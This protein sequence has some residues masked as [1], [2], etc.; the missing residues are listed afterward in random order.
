VDPWLSPPD[1]MWQAEHFMVEPERGLTW[2]RD[3]DFEIEGYT[4]PHLFVY[5]DGRFGM[6][7]GEMHGE[8]FEARSVLTSDDGL[9]W[10]EGAPLF[11][12]DDFPIECGERL[13][14]ATVWI[15]TED[16]YLFILEGYDES[17]SEED[18]PVS[19]FC[20][21][22][23]PDGN[24]FEHQ[25]SYFYE[26]GY[27]G[28]VF[29]VPSAI[30]RSDGDALLFYM[31]HL[32]GE[33]EG[34]HVLEADAD[35]LATQ[36]L[37]DGSIMDEHHVDPDPVYL[38]DGGLRLYHT[39]FW[40]LEQGGMWESRGLAYVPLDEDLLPT[41]EATVLVESD[42]DAGE[43]IFDPSMVRLH[44][45]TLVLYFTSMISGDEGNSFAIKRAF[46]TD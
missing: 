2:E 29:S 23:S 30:S 24:S 20:H 27:E 45:G 36:V 22:T 44:D 13:Q 25:D 6:L 19:Y 28:G 8:A 39:W 3:E 34:I 37:S 4:V 15:R 17:F 41:A 38:A 43:D 5:P 32:G 1:W 10:S 33:N 11:W 40:P 31:D 35:S 12:P 14:D 7:A 42:E 16:S 18:P 26:G 21:A 9:E 46:A